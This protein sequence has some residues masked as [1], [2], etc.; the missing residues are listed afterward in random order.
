MLCVT[1]PFPLSSAK[2]PAPAEA[3]NPAGLFAETALAKQRFA[4]ATETEVRSEKF[5]N[6]WAAPTF[7]ASARFL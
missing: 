2:T 3:S 6:L 5:S 7:A 4:D 1:A